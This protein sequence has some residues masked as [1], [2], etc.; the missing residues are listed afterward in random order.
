M[1]SHTFQ[2]R[3]PRRKGED[4]RSYVVRVITDEC[5]SDIPGVREDMIAE[6]LMFYRGQVSAYVEEQAEGRFGSE[7]RRLEAKLSDLT[8]K[9]TTLEREHAALRAMMPTA[10]SVREA[11]EARLKAARAMRERAA[12]LMEDEGGAPTGASEAI[13]ALPDPRPKWSRA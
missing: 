3:Y 5:R 4:L 8:G 11:E 10:V 12:T 2:M 1:N 9:F 13:R 7:K 6:A